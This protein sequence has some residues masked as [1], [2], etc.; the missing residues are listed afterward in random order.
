M[1]AQGTQ[2]FVDPFYHGN[3]NCDAV[4]VVRA[5]ARVTLRPQQSPCALCI[6]SFAAKYPLR[7]LRLSRGRSRAGSLQRERALKWDALGGASFKPLSAPQVPSRGFFLGGGS[8]SGWLG[9]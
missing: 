2:S 5:D 9:P 1:A 4:A 6:A 3:G 7:G 8:P